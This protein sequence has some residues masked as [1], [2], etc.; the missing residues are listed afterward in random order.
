MQGTMPEMRPEENAMRIRR[1]SRRRMSSPA[2]WLTRWPLV[3]ARS[4][5]SLSVNGFRRQ[6]A[7]GPRADQHQFRFRIG[8]IKLILNIRWTRATF[9]DLASAYDPGSGQPGA[10]PSSC[11]RAGRPRPKHGALLR[12]V[13]R[14]DPLRGFRPRTPLGRIGAAGRARIDLHPSPPVAQVELEKW[15]SRKRRRGYMIRA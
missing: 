5:A 13:D 12:P 7:F 1:P 11:S 6:P 10:P 15:L 14:A 4:F 8:S 2:L 3:R 9:R